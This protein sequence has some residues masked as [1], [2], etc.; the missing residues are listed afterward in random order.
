MSA[1]SFDQLF[2][3]IVPER[4]SWRMR[5]P[6]EFGTVFATEVDLVFQTRSTHEADPNPVPRDSELDLARLILPDLH[7]F[8]AQAEREF[9]SYNPE[10]TDPALHIIR[11]YVLIDRQNI[12]DNGEHWWSVVFPAKEQPAFCWNVEFYRNECQG[13][14]AG[15]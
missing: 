11:P 14:W 2:S 8:L 15:D 3:Q 7:S 4:G 12:E 9:R 13:I 10:L 6:A 5:V 1:S